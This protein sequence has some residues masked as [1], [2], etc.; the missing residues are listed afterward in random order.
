MGYWDVV[1]NTIRKG[2][3]ILVVLDARMPE[4]SRNKDVE[5]LVSKM[6]KIG[7]MVFTKIDLVSNAHLS[8]LKR[9][10]KGAFF[11][12]GLKNIG[13]N[14]LR[15][16]I[17]ITAKRE[18]IDLPKV[19]VVGY[20]N[21][22]K[23]AIINA[24]AHS[25]KTAISSVAGTTKGI[26]YVKAGTLRVIDSPGV[27]P[28]GDDEVKLGLLAARNPEQLKSPELVACKI[29][30]M[31]IESNKKSL[32]KNYGIKIDGKKD[33]YDLMLE[34]G[35]KRKFLIKGGVIDE[36]RTAVQIIRDWQKGKLRI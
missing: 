8:R 35:E 7:F 27:F 20:P 13:M 26:Q 29:I 28:Y 24:L 4:L 32:E 14:Y 10:Y 36:N 33:S 16:Q 11:V 21:I 9:E 15:T 30:E 1:R 6:G 34:I 12:S 25:A 17:F 22:G 2:D 19:G 5:R 3:I 18:R 23:S 31:L